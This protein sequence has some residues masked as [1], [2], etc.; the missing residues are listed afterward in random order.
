[1]HEADSA[2]PAWRAASLILEAGGCPAN[3]FSA[4]LGASLGGAA[5]HAAAAMVA[6]AARPG[7]ETATVVQ[8]EPGSE[9]AQRLATIEA[10]MAVQKAI[11]YYPHRRP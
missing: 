5:R 2:G 3:V 4:A 8:A 10:G 11:G 1:M 6:A 7:H 9:D